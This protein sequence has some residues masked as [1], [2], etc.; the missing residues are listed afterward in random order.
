[1]ARAV[2]VGSS[3]APRKKVIVRSRLRSTGQADAAGTYSAE[4]VARA[5][6]AIA[7]SRK[8]RRNLK[9]VDAVEDSGP[10]AVPAAASGLVGTL[11]RKDLIRGVIFH[12]VLSRPRAIEPYSGP[13]AAG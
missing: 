9:V 12:E 13:P 7:R 3:A 4:S 1:V 10:R 2:P 8:R 6:A 5:K 11:D